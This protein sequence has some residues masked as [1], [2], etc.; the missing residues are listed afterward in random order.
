L[1]AVTGVEFTAFEGASVS[2]GTVVFF[3][4]VGGASAGT[5][6]LSADAL[7]ATAGGVE[8]ATGVLGAL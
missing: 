4:A 6:F 8:A 7:S 1:K 5:T 3:L 2:H